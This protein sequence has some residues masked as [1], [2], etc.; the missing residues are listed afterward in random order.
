MSLVYNAEAYLTA[1][2]IPKDTMMV[3]PNIF[4]LRCMFKLITH[5]IYTYDNKNT[6]QVNKYSL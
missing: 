4:M 5:A 6:L 1:T 2:F 3:Q